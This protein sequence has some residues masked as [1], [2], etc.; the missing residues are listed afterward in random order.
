MRVRHPV[1]C[2]T[3]FAVEALRH[4]KVPDGGDH[5]RDVVAGCAWEVLG[6]GTGRGGA[7]MGRPSESV[8]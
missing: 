2:L 5:E 8:Q 1:A 3:G 6:F 4:P 7:G